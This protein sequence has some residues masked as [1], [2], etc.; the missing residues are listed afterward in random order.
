MN[1][2][3]EDRIS[4]AFEADY[5]PPQSDL[6]RMLWEPRRSRHSRGTML[7][8]VGAV[9]AV[10]ALV[11]VAL[12]VPR[13]AGRQPAP[14]STS[15]PKF[16]PLVPDFG[17][18]VISTVEGLTGHAGTTLVGVEPPGRAAQVLLQLQCSP[19]APLGRLSGQY[20]WAQAEIRSDGRVV[21]AMGDQ[22]PK[23]PA[24]G[25]CG[26]K[27][28]GSSG[29]SG[30]AIVTQ[31]TRISITT[32]VG[33]R[34]RAALE[35]ARTPSSV[36][37]IS[38]MPKFLGSCPSSLVNWGIS[39]ASGT[40]FWSLTLYPGLDG[41]AGASSARSSCDLKVNVRLGIYYVATQSP[42]AQIPAS[43]ADQTISGPLT[44]AGGGPQGALQAT[45]DW[46][47]WCGSRHPVQAVIFGPNSVVLGE[48]SG[49][50]PPACHAGVAG[51]DL[52]AGS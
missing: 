24:P 28:S 9:V 26:P 47:N 14:G 12:S 32:P 42:I 30:L 45:W 19:G 40:G 10:A 16:S 51:L 4:A 33:I 15:T 36:P 39:T 2:S 18:E 37:P 6:R 49:P 31:P 7:A 17:Y 21:S 48:V 50:A 34:W 43:Q 35:V 23:N 25:R 1:S 29:G 46:G 13:V 41:G 22:S 27:G 5:Q 11:G 52:R 44:A 8:R 38:A 20:F 3:L